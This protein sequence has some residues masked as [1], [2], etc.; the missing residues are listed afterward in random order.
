MPFIALGQIFFRTKL[1][2]KLRQAELLI[3]MITVLGYVDL[4]WIVIIYMVAL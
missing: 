1:T 4:K 3:Q 2:Y